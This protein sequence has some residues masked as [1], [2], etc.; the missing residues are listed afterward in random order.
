MTLE[1]GPKLFLHQ[2]KTILHSAIFLFIMKIT[3][4]Q[5]LIII[6]SSVQ[7][8]QGKRDW[9][10]LTYLY[11]TLLL[12]LCY[13]MLHCCRSRNTKH[14]KFSSRGRSPFKNSALKEK[15]LVNPNSLC[16]LAVVIEW[17][18]CSFLVLKGLMTI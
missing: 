12:K 13:E 15:L 1:K 4:Y 16:M 6:S 3:F 7:L 11:C 8:V 18:P 14:S 2:F 9:G 17:L 5:T 10:S